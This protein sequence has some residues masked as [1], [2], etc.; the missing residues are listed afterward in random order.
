MSLRVVRFNVLLLGATNSLEN[1]VETVTEI[2]WIGVAGVVRYLIMTSAIL[3]FL[4]LVDYIVVE[5]T[6]SYSRQT[7]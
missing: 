3:N 1:L 2:G 4:S 5:V 6:V 7:L